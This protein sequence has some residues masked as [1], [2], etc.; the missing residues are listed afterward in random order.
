[1]GVLRVPAPA[2]LNLFLKVL[3]RRSDGYHNLQTLFHFIDAC[4]WL[5]FELK[6][7]PG[8]TL[9]CEQTEL[10]TTDNLILKAAR[11][12]EAEAR[13]HG[14]TNLP[15]VHIRLEKHLPVGGGIGGGSS[16]A[17]TT[18]LALNQLW[19]LRLSRQRLAELAL[20]LGADVPV[21]ILG[22]SALGE[23]RGEILTSMDIPE[24]FYLLAKPRC[25]VSTA[26]VFQHQELTRDSS[27]RTIRAFPGGAQSFQ[28]LLEL[29]AIGNDCQSL[30]TK[31]Y[32][33]IDQ[34]IALLGESAHAQLTGTGACVFAAFE[35]R[36]SAE[37]AL[38]RLQGNPVIEQI[39]LV[40]GMNH[41]PLN[42]HIQDVKHRTEHNIT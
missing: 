32:P 4:D 2:K 17:A 9:A 22:Q 26:E 42:K 14:K 18:L 21:F 33:E 36:D 29:I 38:V 39:L 27:P 30:V 8:L 24:F 23:G 10:N 5:T 28:A 15:G 16:D 34:T 37:Q 11:L 35:T 40:K 12:L 13:Q 31:L 25:H 41:S 20:S 3:N 7:Q 1:M 19:H 6:D